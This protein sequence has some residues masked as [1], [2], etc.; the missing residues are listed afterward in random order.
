MIEPPQIATTDTVHVA[1]IPLTVP[2]DQIPDV[3]GPGIN[4]VMAAIAAQGLAPAGPL[5][6]HHL[7]IEPAIFDFEICVPVASP[8]TPFGRVRAGVLPGA[9]VV[10]TVYRG[11]YEGLGAAW[12]EFKTWIAEHAHKARGDLWECYLVGP[13]S[14]A[15]PA[16]WRT[17]LNQPLVD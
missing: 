16:G 17:E 15:D 13:E 9:T 7:R 11:P 2:R 6:T 8:I 14:G 12:G 3:M 1:C 5:F 4:E 10:R